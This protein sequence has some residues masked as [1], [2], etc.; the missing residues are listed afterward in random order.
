MDRNGNV[1]NI[2]NKDIPEERL[3]AICFEQ[4]KNT[5][6]THGNDAHLACCYACATKTMNAS[7]SCPICR[8]TITSVTKVY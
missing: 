1:V 7:K 6:F 5:L 8:K 3:C 2:K 4:E